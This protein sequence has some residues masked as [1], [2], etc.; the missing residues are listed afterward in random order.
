MSSDIIAGLDELKRFSRQKNAKKLLEVVKS[1]Y[2]YDFLAG[3]SSPANI[4]E[5]FAWYYRFDRDPEVLDKLLA[6]VQ[7][8]TAQDIDSFAQ[9]YFVPENRAVLTLA[10]EAPK[11]APQPAGPAAQK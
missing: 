9:T 2:R 3:L 5:T 11:P 4:A 10:Y 8:L 1:K 7:K 6:S